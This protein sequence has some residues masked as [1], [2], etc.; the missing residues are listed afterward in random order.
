MSKLKYCAIPLVIAVLL[1]GLTGIQRA[2]GEPWGP[3]CEFSGAIQVINNPPGVGSTITA[4]TN[5]VDIAST[6]VGGG[7]TYTISVPAEDEAIAGTQGAYN[8]NLITFSYNGRILGTGIFTSGGTVSLDLHPPEA[9]PGGP[10]VARQSTS[11]TLNGSASDPFAG[12]S[13]S[14]AWDLDNDGGYGDSSAQNP[15]VS[16]PVT[17]TQ[18]VGLRVTDSQGGIGT[19]NA[20]VV[21]V[22]LSGLTGQTY[23]GNP[24]PVTVT[25]VNAPYSAA[26][27]Y[28]GSGTAPTNAGSYSVLVTV[29][30]G[31]GP[32]GSISATL[33]VNQRAASVTPNAAGKLYGQSD[34]ALSGTLTG[35]LAGDGVT[36]T[37]SRTPGESV[38]T[39][40]ISAQLSP[41]GVLTNYAITYNTATFTISAL[42]VTVTANSGQSKVYGNADPTFTYTA[43]EPISFTG[44]LSRV[45]GE[46]VGTYAITQGTLSAGSNYTIIFVSASFSITPRPV[47]VTANART[48]VYGDA[49]PTL[50]YT[51]TLMPG[52]NFSGALSRETG[53]AVG[54]YAITQGTLTA[55]ANYTITFNG[56]TFTIT[57]RPLTVTA[58]ARSKAYGDA[59]PTLTYTYTGTLV[60]GDSF[61]GGLVREVGEAVGTYAINRGTLTAG[62]NY[63]I[64][65]NGATF[66]I[67]QRPL[68]V[69]ADARSKV[70]G[71][72][73]PAL[74]YTYTGT[75][76]PG[77]NFSGTLTRAPGENVGT[78]PI[79]Q[80]SL[81][82]GSNYA[83]TFVSA[84]FTITALPVTVTANSGQSKV[85][86][87]AD[88]TFTYTSSPVVSF[89]GALS[90]VAGENVGTYAITQG[91]LSAGSN[92]AITFVSATFAITPRPV[93]VTATAGQTK[94]YGNADPSLTYS[95][96]LQPG[97]SFTGALSRVAGEN[98]GSY[99]ITQGTL[100]AGSNYTITFVSANFTITQRSLTVTADARSK[101]YGAADPALTY[102]Y[103]GTL[104]PGDSFSGGL[105]RVAGEAVGTYAI[106]LGTLTAGSNYTITYNGATFTI[107][108]RP[109]TVTATPGQSKVYGNPD[110]VFAYTSSETVTFTG[111]LSRAAGE[112]VGSYAITQGTLSAGSNYTITFVSNPFTITALPVTVTAN[113]GQSKVYGNPDPTF[114]YTSSPVV[115][116]TGALSRVAGEN[117]GTYA[118]TLG[119]LSAGS[120]YTITFVPANFSITPRALTVTANARTKVYGD[121]DPALTYSYTGTLVSG[122]SFSGS[123][124]RA[125][126]EN[127][128]T[129]AITQGTLTAGSNYTI[130]FNG[131]NFTITPRPITVTATPGQS[132][133]YGAADPVFAYTSSETVTFTGALS[134]VAGEAVGSYAITLGTLSAGSNY[135]ITF[136]SANF[137]ITAQP[138][139]VTATPGQSKVYGNA[140]PV[141]AYTSSQPVSFTGSL[142]RAAGENVGSYAITIGTLSAG[143]NYTITF[144][145]ANFTITPRPVTVT[146]TAGQSKVYGNADPV[147]AYTSSEVVTYT[148]SLSRA[149][150]E[151]VGSYA[152]NLGTLSA[153]ANY[154][155]TFVPANFTITARPVTVTANSGQ[156]KVYGNADPTLTYTGTLV[157]GDSFSG[158]L[159]RVAGE[160]VGSYAI[161]QGTLTA[162]ANYTI[163]FV[164]AN[165]AITARPLTVTANAQ[166]K[167]Y[168]DVD[169]ALTYTFTG[170][171]VTGDSFTGALARVAGENVGAY[172]INQGTLTAGANYTITYVG[173][174]LTITSRA[175]AVT[176]TAATKVYGDADP[177]FAY[178]YTGTLLTGDSFSGAL[179]RA[180]GEAIGTYAINQGTLTAGPNY[181]ITFT[182]ANLTITAR[183]LTVTATA[184]TKVYGD[185]DPVLA[186]TFTG[187]LAT[188]DSFTGALARAAGE[189]VGTY[190]INQG[191]LT[192]GPN[193]TITFTGANLTITARPLTVTAT[194]ATKVY[195]DADPVFAYTYTGTLVTGDA[196]TGALARAAG[197]NVGTYAIN[198]GTLTAG[199]NYPITF[200]AANL[201]ITARPLTVTATAATKVY[202]DVD[203]VFA[204]T[205]TGTLV[206][207]DAFTG[208]LARAAGTNVGTY[209]I[210]IGTLTAGTNYTITFVAANLTITA[211]PLTVTAD[212]KTKVYGDADPALTYTYTGT[213]VTGDAFTGALTRAAGTN[214]GTYAITQGTLTAGTNYAITYTPANLTITARPITVTADAKSKIYGAADPAL[215]WTVTTGSLVSGDSLTGALVRAAGETVGTYAINQG[216]LA[217]TANYTLTYVA[218]VFTINPNQYAISLVPGWNLVSFNI[219]PLN[220]AIASVLAS[221]EGNYTLV[222]AW[223]AS[224]ASAAT[225]NWL[226][227]DTEPLSADTLTTLTEQMGFWIY[228][229]AADTLQVS[230]TFQTTT[231]TG[232]SSG[233]GGWN[234]VGYAS[235]TN[236]ALPAALRDLGVGTNYSLVYS[237][238]A[239]DAGDPWKLYDR[240]ATIG[241]DLTTMAP[242]WGYWIKVTAASNW[243]VPY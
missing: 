215:T 82:A 235:A 234:L 137:T 23:D 230:G 62:S 125:A 120:N 175:L 150:G 28:N 142:S 79:G 155:I 3:P 123:L 73:D 72:A 222:Y 60:P 83:I 63:T 33:V 81:T 218:G 241:N 242:G 100:S 185:A 34:P 184:A 239:N 46:N 87:N 205:Y 55:G 118:I 4:S 182:G 78:Y 25:G 203:P 70:Y 75:L 112:N 9:D 229:T 101:V 2:A 16:F 124:T 69:T 104:V 117:V 196:F 93:T 178:T 165:F 207:G 64:T 47:T 41:S 200:V 223:D 44:A 149:A 97:D 24:K 7:L 227:Y 164:P 191:T 170:T 224:G 166:T 111:A 21:V 122:D 119:T 176:A 74:T 27:T 59:D 54:S 37:Y 1:L 92:Y 94:V 49:D 146:A 151:N 243:A 216:T 153:G 129:Y 187:T 143:S 30:D 40:T 22:G 225:G 179:A 177:V 14:Y 198:S 180:A 45:A 39:Y 201:P 98:V 12:D 52:D 31:G 172:A 162:G 85:Y 96:T 209:A 13:I 212:A 156:S 105:A 228:M 109:I 76:M 66:T 186:Y 71:A 158:A 231:T 219:R 50:T 132:K 10:Y 131:A 108:P 133:V 135:T 173:A 154:T 202:G 107:T 38:G 89:T 15:S 17:G 88:P 145:P 11:I 43:S 67:T 121:A 214:V 53:E 19:A 95:G 138:I 90:R 208:A 168:G 141:F 204:Y 136:V 113:A 110:P 226:K 56:A 221:L 29:S 194:A 238:R 8:G 6:T 159:S 190:A 148:G 171:L 160:N 48:K 167:Q 189:A 84:N 236:R 51:G 144:V 42:P 128:G 213:L 5:G 80:G 192:A 197:T 188:G 233:A 35:F 193:Y 102:T 210:N 130:T 161:T 58:N 232:L 169:P 217:A 36:A 211:R 99:A 103:T 174:N 115:S 199:T 91:T 61:S 195:G 18:T 140:D 106:N 32:I 220:T 65:Y 240:T 206:T 139:T 26:V 237:Y 181:T 114:T 126:G 127:V 20:S 152:I 163:T 147:F 157:S 116:F 134:R 68:T 183:P 57:Q 77:D 86:G